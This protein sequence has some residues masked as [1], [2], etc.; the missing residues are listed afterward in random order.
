MLLK[1]LGKY[2]IVEWL[3]GG[4]FGDVFLARDTI[5]DKEFALK[6]S[7][8]RRE[9]IAMLK[10]E[11]TLLASLDHPNIV[12]FYNVDFVDNK[13]VLVM[14]YVQGENL[15]DIIIE[16]GIDIKRTVSILLQLIDALAYAHRSHVLHRDLKPENILISKKKNADLIKITDFGLA[17][18][19][20]AG[21]ISASSAGTPIYMAPESWGGSHSERSDIWSLGVILYEMLTGAPPFLDDSLDGL[22]RKIDKASF[23]APAVFRHDIPEPIERIALSALAKDPSSRPTLDEIKRRIERMDDGIP[24]ERVRMPKRKSMDMQLTSVQ[25]DVLAS[26]A[27]PVLVHGK[28]GCGKTT[29]L[30][31]AI[32]ALLEKGVPLS[33][34]LTCTFTN[35]AADDIRERLQKTAV[36][37]TRDLWLGTIHMAA[38]RILRRDAERLD[39]NPDFVIKDAK[40]IVQEMGV[41]VGKYRINAVLRSIELIKAKGITADRFRAKNN[42]ERVCSEV[43]RKYE[44]YTRKESTIDYDDLILL[45]CRLLED[46]TDVR[47][48]YQGI[49]DYI[50]VD[51]LQDI[52]PAQ[53]RLIGLMSKENIFFTGDE[54]QAIYGWRGAQRNLM[55]QVQKDY[56][57]VRVFNLNQSF[58]L[59]R[60]IIDIASNLMHRE[61]TVIPDGHESDIIVHA[62][63]SDEDEAHYIVKEIERLHAEDFG[64]RDMVI[65]CRMNQLARIYEAALA[66]ARIPH[67][68]ISGSSLYERGEVKLIIDYL[69]ALREC[70]A[71][72]KTPDDLASLANGIFTLPKRKAKRALSVYEYHLANLESLKPGKLIGDILDLTDINGPEIDDLQSLATSQEFRTLGSFLNQIRLLQEL[73][74]AEWNKDMVK[75]MTVHSAKGLQFPVVFVVD[76]VEDTFPLTKKMASQQEVDEERRLC[77]VALTRAQKKLYL[78]YP[79]WRHG[80]YQHPSRFLVEMFKTAL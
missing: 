16:G 20:R 50:F 76:L 43:Y 47:Q 25:K 36:T 17:K 58:R 9:E 41:D 65:L 39:L 22:K 32:N 18:F 80:R 52:N 3:G 51:E 13:F 30:T 28:A 6:I 72:L 34:I 21:S 75:V 57:A 12:R 15:R 19:I 42:W 14:E 59:A 64:Y 66:K 74:L 11:A 7:R 44:D 49:F 38:F 10:E 33:K 29:T 70:S 54:D 67:V 23:V 56:P 53:Y 79:K 31:L 40:H 37:H 27:G 1:N 8:M 35:R 63:K 5:I 71:G 69:D 48:H 78:L 62:A 26:I 24:G 45:S 77:Y 60:S 46:N 73:D 4:R 68:L 61:A 2:E 55:H